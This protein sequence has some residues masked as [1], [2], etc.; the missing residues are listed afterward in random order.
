MRR[1]DRS[2]GRATDPPM[3]WK[4]RL[5]WALWPGFLAAVVAEAVFFALFDPLE[6]DLHLHLSR[7]AAYTF[8]FIGFWLLG[9]LSSSL[10]LFLEHTASSPPAAATDRWD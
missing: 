9:T 1:R 7:E 2:A 3:R 4:Q 5:I 10:T 6:I 8:G